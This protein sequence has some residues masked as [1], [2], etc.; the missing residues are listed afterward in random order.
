MGSVDA[1]RRR[2][3]GQPT[4][5]LQLQGPPAHQRMGG[6]R[7][8][9]VPRAVDAQHPKLPHGPAAAA[10]SRRRP[11]VPRRRW[12]PSSDSRSVPS[13]VGA[14]RRPLGCRVR[15]GAPGVPG[16][17]V[18]PL[19]SRSAEAESGH[20]WRGDCPSWPGPGAAGDGAVPVP[21]REQVDR[22]NPQSFHHPGFPP[23]TPSMTA[24][25][26][27]T[28]TPLRAGRVMVGS[29]SVQWSMTTLG[30]RPSPD[31]PHRRQGRDVGGRL[32]KAA[33][34]FSCSR[35]DGGL[36]GT[37]VWECG[38]NRGRVRRRLPAARARA[39]GG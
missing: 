20:R 9:A 1:R 34:R 2:I 29:P 24:N 38:K 3:A 4:P 13:V 8:A 28:S 6:Q 26:L 35:A 33:A 23:F 14:R 5:P 25:T 37:H 36:P 17:G 18:D 32:Q 15:H 10:P 27:G 7:V 21:G 22:R 30:T 16:S 39:G 12:H 19:S 11:F 31:L